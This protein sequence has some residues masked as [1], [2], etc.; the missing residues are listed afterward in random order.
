MT[1]NEIRAVL[2]VETALL[3][4]EKVTPEPMLKQEAAMIRESF[5]RRR[6]ALERVHDPANWRKF[7][8]GNE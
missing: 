6:V 2:N 7:A 1:D 4:L 3:R 8:V 5:Q